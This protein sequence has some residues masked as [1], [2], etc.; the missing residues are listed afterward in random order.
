MVAH[1]ASHQRRY[2][3]LTPPGASGPK[4]AS[5][6]GH[7]GPGR[8]PPTRSHDSPSARDACPCPSPTP[9]LGRLAGHPRMVSGRRPPLRTGPRRPRSAHRAAP[10]SRRGGS[11]VRSLVT[12]RRPCRKD[13]DRHRL[14]APGTMIA[15]Q[16][17]VWTG[18]GNVPQ[19]HTVQ[20]RER[21][22]RGPGGGEA[23]RR[24]GRLYNGA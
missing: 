6:R 23:C 5:P 13:R 3:R 14:I 24:D 22:D 12:G 9:C 8:P 4:L 7:R 10:S 16:G 2:Q 18:E 11:E 21:Q 17:L 19:D 20:G 1:P 15:V